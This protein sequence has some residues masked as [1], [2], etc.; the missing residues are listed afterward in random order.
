MGEHYRQLH[1]DIKRAA[2]GEYVPK[3]PEWVQTAMDAEDLGDI[4]DY[5]KEDKTT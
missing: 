4:S 2:R 3:E 1:E 5:T